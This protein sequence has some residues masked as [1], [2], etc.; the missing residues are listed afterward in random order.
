MVIKMFIWLFLFMTAYAGY[1][2]DLSINISTEISKEY[3]YFRKHENSY[4][5]NI[6]YLLIHYKNSGNSNIYFKKLVLDSQILSFPNKEDIFMVAHKIEKLKTGQNK[7]IKV[8]TYPSETKFFVCISNPE[9][10]FFIR[11]NILYALDLN[12]VQAC[13]WNTIEP[14]FFDQIALLKEILTWQFYLNKLYPNKE[15]VFFDYPNKNI[16]S[17][18][19]IEKK[20]F[21][22]KDSNTINTANDY[23]FS[24]EKFENEFIFLKKNEVYT[25]RLNIL[26][27]LLIGGNYKFYLGKYK[28]QDSIKIYN[29]KIPN[30]IKFKLPDEY[31]NYKLYTGEFQTNSTNIIFDNDKGA[32]FIGDEK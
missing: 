7:I 29:D 17:F 3:V 12:Q 10:K 30:F 9:Q 18:S 8:E 25:Q 28:F 31:H 13:N 23:A 20:P 32:I 2:Q 19:E 6:P 14:L 4:K 15:I 1:S 11:N 22:G 21:V 24:L 5:V 26:P 16:I 27:F